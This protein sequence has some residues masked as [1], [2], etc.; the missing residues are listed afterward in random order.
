VNSSQTN[1]LP[2]ELSTQ[3]PLPVS[4][5]AGTESSEIPPLAPINLNSFEAK[6]VRRAPNDEELAVG[7]VICNDLLCSIQHASCIL[8]NLSFHTLGK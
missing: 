8:H 2:Y 3:S 1:E 7:C 6:F 4:M 5:E